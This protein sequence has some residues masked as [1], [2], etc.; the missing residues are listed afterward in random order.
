MGSRMA[1]CQEQCCL[2][3]C[4]TSSEQQSQTETHFKHSKHMLAPAPLCAC[5]PPP[6][7]PPAGIKPLVVLH[8]WD[9]PQALQQAYGGFLGPQIVEDFT[10]FADNAFRLFGDRVHRW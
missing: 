1:L 3:L 4:S 8:H 2:G 7:L 6:P 5:P 10:W 9:L